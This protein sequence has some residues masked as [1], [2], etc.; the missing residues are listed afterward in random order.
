MFQNIKCN[1]TVA[2]KSIHTLEFVRFVGK[3]NEHK[4]STLKVLKVLDERNKD[5]VDLELA[6]ICEILKQLPS[7]KKKKKKTQ[8][9]KGV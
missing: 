4:Y 8:L 3:A 5:S 7:C 2:C 6:F 9:R 1:Y